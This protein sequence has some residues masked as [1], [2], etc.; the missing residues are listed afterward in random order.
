MGD[1]R[2]S[3]L[4]IDDERGL[5]DG[6][7]ECLLFEG[8]TAYVE[9]D[10]QLG[11]DT[12]KNK[13]PD[14]TLIDV[15]LAYN[16]INGIEVLKKIREADPSAMCIMVTRITDQ[17]T[18]DKAKDFGAYDYILKPLEGDDIVEVINRIS[19]EIDQRGLK[20]AKE[21]P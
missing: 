4:I 19:K 1:K 9:T 3:V 15:V 13:R 10:G 20:D 17:S 2:I 6:I 12:F 16:S 8:Y 5:A 7:Q 11:V 18:V 14:V 21:T